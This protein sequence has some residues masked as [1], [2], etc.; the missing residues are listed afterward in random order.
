MDAVLDHVVLQ[1]FLLLLVIKLSQAAHSCSL[2]HATAI[3]IAAV[4]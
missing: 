4:L 2:S 3:A 1:E